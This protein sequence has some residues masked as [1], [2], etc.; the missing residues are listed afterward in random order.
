MKR[1]CSKCNASIGEFDRVCHK[2][3]HI[4]RNVTHHITQ[5][6]HQYHVIRDII[7]VIL[8]L[9]LVYWAFKV[10]TPE[11]SI[12]VTSPDVNV[13]DIKV[14]PSEVTINIPPAETEKP[15]PQERDSRLDD[16]EN[17]YRDP[18]R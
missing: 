10:Y 3:G 5:K 15:T 1:V 12:I 4:F 11:R 7:L 2:C 13:P 14:P 6:P 8:V 16:L 17:A 9:L 18:Y